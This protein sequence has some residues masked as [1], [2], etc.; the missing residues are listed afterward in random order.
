[1]VLS[2]SI[3]SSHYSIFKEPGPHCDKKPKATFPQE[4]WFQAASY[5]IIHHKLIG[6]MKCLIKEKNPAVSIVI[7]SWPNGD[8]WIMHD[9]LS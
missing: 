1:M 3:F 9:Q 5:Y 8:R 2:I 7:T 4:K 6:K